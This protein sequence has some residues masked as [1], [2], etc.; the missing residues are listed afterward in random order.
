MNKLQD[1]ERYGKRCKGKKE[2]MA[3]LEGTPLSPKQSIAAKCYDCM[4][5]GEVDV[6]GSH[7]CTVS[8]CALYPYMPYNENKRVRKLNISDERRKQMGDRLRKT[9]KAAMVLL[10]LS[11]PS[12]PCAQTTNE[13]IISPRMNNY[14][15]PLGS[16]GSTSNPYVVKERYDGNLEIRTRSQDFNRDLMAPG[17]PTNPYIVR[18]R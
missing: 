16:A 2:L 3:Y 18:P 9:V 6:N 13:W 11:I 14:N 15:Q 4:G 8:D 1:V 10:I 12:I 17:Q 7:D 5:Y